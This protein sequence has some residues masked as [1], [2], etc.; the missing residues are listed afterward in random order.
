MRHGNRAEGVAPQNVYPCAGDDAVAITVDTDDAGKRSSISLATS[1]CHDGA[2]RRS[3][4][5][6]PPRHHRRCHL[7]VDAHWRSTSPLRCRLGVIAVPVMTNRDLVE[8]EHLVERGFVAVWDQP[9]V[10]LRGFPGSPLHFSRTPVQLTACP[11][12]GQHNAAVLA[13]YLGLS[14]DDVAGLLEKGV[15]ADRPPA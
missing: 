3:T 5:V 14:D 12:L 6:L 1:V 4:S 13:E 11:A 9:D 7:Y 2:M 8:N 15:I 10:G